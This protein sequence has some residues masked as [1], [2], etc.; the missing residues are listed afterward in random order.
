MVSVVV[1]RHL[2][3]VV[4]GDD[5]CRAPL[6]TGVDYRV[7]GSRCGYVFLSNCI[8]HMHYIFPL[9]TFFKICKRPTPQVHIFSHVSSIMQKMVVHEF[10]LISRW[11]TPA[12]IIKHLIE[13]NTYTVYI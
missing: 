13:R 1:Q 5:R 11:K 7:C 4:K 2:L 8:C 3:G 9:Y 12:K 10:M 6:L